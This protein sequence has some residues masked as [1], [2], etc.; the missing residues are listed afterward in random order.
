MRE[1][2]IRL[3]VPDGVEVRIEDVPSHELPP[4]LETPAV[5]RTTATA[6]PATNGWAVGQ[7]HADGHNPLRSNSRGLFCPT[8]VNGAFCEW[9]P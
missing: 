2:V 9:K 3:T 4:P 1:I 8:K 6:Q 5:F 7:V